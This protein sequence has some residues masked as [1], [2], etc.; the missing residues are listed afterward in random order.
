MRNLAVVPDVTE[1]VP[2]AQRF[3]VPYIGNEDPAVRMSI[4]KALANDAGLRLPDTRL[5]ERTALLPIGE[6]A[7]RRMQGE[8]KDLPDLHPGL[9]AYQARLKAEN[10]ID[11][12]VPIQGIRMNAL[13]GGIYG[14]GLPGEQSLGYTPTGFSHTAQFLKPTTIRSGF[15]ENI[16]ALPPKLAAD[17]FNHWADV[18]KRK[19]DVVL[20]TFDGGKGRIIRAVTSDSHSLERGDDLA[21][22]SALMSLPY[23]AKLRVTRAPGGTMSEIEVI[24]P[25][26]D[27]QLKV[28]DVA[29]G[30]VRIRN[31]ETKGGSL[32][33]EAF[34]LRVL[35]YNFTT[36]FSEDDEA[37]TVGLRHVGDL[38]RRIA[39][40]I[41]GAGERIEPLVRAFGDAYKDDFPDVMQTRGEVLEKVGKVFELP[42]TTLERAAQLWDADGIMG[43]G[44]T[45]AGLVHAL[46]RASQEQSVTDAGE[47]ERVAGRIILDGWGAL[48]S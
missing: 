10:P 2:H 47:T 26:L 20:R 13:T 5:P 36:A 35:C 37:K 46:T 24:W 14:P 25:M 48:A 7:Q 39:S 28:G 15:S 16:L 33:I 21:V 30:G 23:G 12:N 44:D 22:V 43:A 19:E 42:A 17:V 40:A 8:L 45:R 29:Y 34:L 18:S 38:R 11:A 41:R 31:S 4:L 9:F 1:F 6:E 32:R 3:A 27:R